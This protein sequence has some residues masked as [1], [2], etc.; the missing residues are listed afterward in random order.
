[1]V[2]GGPFPSLWGPSQH[3]KDPW[4]SG[5]GSVMLRTQGPDCSVGPPLSLGLGPVPA[6][7]CKQLSHSQHQGWVKTVP[8]SASP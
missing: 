7:A 6:A 3:G 8:S 1:M 4:P 2:P 5:R